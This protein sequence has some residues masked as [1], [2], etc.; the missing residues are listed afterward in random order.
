MDANH[1]GI[2]AGDRL[3]FRPFSM[4]GELDVVNQPFQVAFDFFQGLFFDVA[5]HHKLRLLCA[6]VIRRF[7]AQAQE[8]R[9]SLFEVYNFRFF[10]ADF[11]T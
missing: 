4:S 6:A 2:V 1:V 10:R 9:I 5:F 7:D 11:Q 8:L 3:I